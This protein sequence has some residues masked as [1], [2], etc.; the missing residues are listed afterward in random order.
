MNFSPTSVPNPRD[1]ESDA[2]RPAILLVDNYDSFVHNL[3]RYL[4]LAGARTHTV[5]NDQ[6]DID[7]VLASPP[8]GVVISPGPGHPRDAG[9]SVELIRRTPAEIPLLGVCLGHQAIAMAFGGKV[10]TGPPVHGSASDLFHDG[11]GLMTGCPSPTPVGRYHSLCLDR[12]SLPEQLI[13]TGETSDQVVMAVRHRTRPI[14][15]LQFHP[16]SVLT[17]DGQRMIQSFVDRVRHRLDGCD[18]A[19][20][21][22]ERESSGAGTVGAKLNRPMEAT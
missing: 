22:R 5:R 12:N 17:R 6:I 3:G 14:F 2:D 1:P 20:D 19:E 9:V 8:D 4:R 10:P 18:E 13:V 15:G 11:T 21:A 7:D 16:E